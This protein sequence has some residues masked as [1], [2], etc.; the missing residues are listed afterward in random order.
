MQRAVPTVATL[1]VG[2]LVVLASSFA[3]QAGPPGTWTQITK[4]HNGSKPNLGLARAKD[5]TLHVLWAGPGRAPYTAVLDTTISPSGKVGTPKPVVSGWAA[6][7]VPA[8]VTAPDGTIHVVI[9]G[10]KVNSNSDP[11][12]GLTE[13]VGPG[14]WKVADKA[15]GNASISEASNA[16]VSTSWAKD[17]QLA[18]AWGT[19]AKLLF[20][21][22]VDPA[23]TPTDFT[24][25]PAAAP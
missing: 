16:D 11:N 12:S 23:T 6:V 13:V 9:S 3:A 14:A 21:H 4:Q 15:F 24:T 10:Q 22:G 7:H 20:Q 25:V 18:T 17:G 19:A 2:A 5:G 1:A 8:A